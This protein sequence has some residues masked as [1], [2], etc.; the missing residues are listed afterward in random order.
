MLKDTEKTQAG[1]CAV[2]WKTAE[3]RIQE[4]KAFLM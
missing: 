2:N 1:G 3:R 4:H